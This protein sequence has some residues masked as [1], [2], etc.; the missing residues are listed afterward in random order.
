MCS[1][2]SVYPVSS[3]GS[4]VAPG[5]D[6]R[7]REREVALFW[8]LRVDCPT[9]SEEADRGGWRWVARACKN[10]A[11]RTMPLRRGHGPRARCSGSSTHP[12]T[13]SDGSVV[14][15]TANHVLICSVRTHV[16]TALLG[17]GEVWH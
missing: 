3:R 6:P 8:G 1:I 14:P 12:S 17:Q 11:P 15:S 16:G 10:R 7:C 5:C 9:S 2:D 13:S 4:P